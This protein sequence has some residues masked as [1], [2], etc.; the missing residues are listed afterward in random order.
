[1]HAA[2]AKH[3]GNVNLIDFA[4]AGMFRDYSRGPQSWAV[5]SVGSHLPAIKAGPAAAAC[6][7]TTP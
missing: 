4:A 1:L 5:A 3:L 2:R 7:T 6:C